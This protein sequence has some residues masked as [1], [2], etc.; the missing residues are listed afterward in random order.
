MI[1]VTLDWADG[2]YIFRLGL[3]QLEEL[4]AVCD[5]GPELLE[6]RLESGIPNA[7]DL[8][9]IIRLGLIGGGTEPI[10]ALT[11]VERYVDDAPRM[12]NHLVARLVIQA[13]LLGSPDD[14]VGK[15]QAEADPAATSATENGRSH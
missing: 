9:E 3:K 8:R 2:R 1:S 10:R 12:P 5:A 11:L 6:K 7:R 15:S 14:P 4:Q 13:C